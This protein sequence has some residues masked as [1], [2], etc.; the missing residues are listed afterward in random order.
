MRE[1]LI[2]LLDL[3][4]IVAYRPQ[5]AR[6]LGSAT[7]ALFLSQAIYWQQKAGE[8]HYFYKKRDAERDNN[9]VM[10]EPQTSDQQ[11][12]EWELGL[13][14]YE[15]ESSRKLLKK[16]NLLEEKLY[17]MPAKTYYRVDYDALVAFLQ[18]NLT[19]AIP[20]SNCDNNQLD[21]DHHQVGGKTT[22][23]LAGKPPASKAETDQAV[24]GNPSNKLDEK[25]PTIYKEAKTTTEI[26]A[27]IAP[28][29]PPLGNLATNTSMHPTLNLPV[30][31]AKYPADAENP[32][33]QNSGENLN[34]Q[35]L[36]KQH[37]LSLAQLSALQTLDESLVMPKFINDLQRVQVLQMLSSLDDAEL[38]QTVLDELA[39]AVARGNIKMPTK[40][41]AKLTTDALNGM[42]IPDA[43]IAIK[44]ARA[45]AKALQENQARSLAKAKLESTAVKYAPTTSLR[46]TLADLNQQAVNQQVER[47]S[48]VR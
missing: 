6:A 21:S 13:S 16:Y 31:I 33:I 40:L 27:N 42:F 11:S 25:P 26:T 12:W 7:A 34:K 2:D 17:G 48:H 15:Q 41:L 28:P 5:F 24:G 4:S 29:L 18:A 20:T 38:A 44:Q 10:L 14:R 35:H 22:N 46:Q 39:G 47:K 32:K 19:K 45:N 30:G 36:S 9:D 37:K 43:A 1:L 3:K 8:G 23:K